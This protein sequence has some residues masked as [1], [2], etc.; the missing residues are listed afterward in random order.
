MIASETADAGVIGEV[1]GLSVCLAYRYSRCALHLRGLRTQ[2]RASLGV[3][4]L[5]SS[6]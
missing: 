3:D 5:V 6:E 2:L 1:P 4:L